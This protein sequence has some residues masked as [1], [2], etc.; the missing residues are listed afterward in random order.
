M[1]DSSLLAQRWVAI[2]GKRDSP[3]DGVEDYCSF[4]SQALFGL[5]IQMTLARVSWSAPGWLR[6]LW[7][8]WKDSATWTNSRVLMQ[9]TALGW[10]RRGFPFGALAV[11]CIL[12][13][14]CGRMAVVFHEHSRQAA[15]PGLLSRLRGICQDMVTKTLYHISDESVFLAPLDVV[16]WLRQS[17]SKACFIPIG[18]N[19]PERIG[20]RQPT[21]C[22]AKRIAL[23]GI[24]G[25]P[26]RDVE[27]AVIAACIRRTIKSVADIELIVLGRGSEEA[28]PLLV[29]AFGDSRVV[30]AAKGVLPAK[31]IADELERAD[32]LLFVRGP[33][34]LRRGSALAGIACGVPIVGY[35][36]GGVEFPLESAGIE[37]A[38][39]DAESLAKCLVRVLTDRSL[40]SHLH[41]RN[42]RIQKEHFSWTRIA[43][44]YWNA[45]PR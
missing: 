12:K 41:D 15:P 20:P 16:P 28:G 36:G 27:V 24:T 1:A 11:A 22:G 9:Y 21:I 5:N 6:A 44:Q 8:L 19:I 39:D 26:A 38:K 31:Q 25:G 7:R 14:R 4:L 10:S 3:T 13:Y 42:V 37:W 45:L 35:H 30:V 32:V 2:L 23:F 43:Q 29:K 33:I 34:T 17:D 18:A 40:W